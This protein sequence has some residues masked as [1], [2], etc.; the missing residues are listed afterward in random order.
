MDKIP[1]WVGVE[2]VFQVMWL[3]VVLSVPVVF[4][5]LLVKYVKSVERNER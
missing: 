4:G 5:V 2:L 3:L 1:F